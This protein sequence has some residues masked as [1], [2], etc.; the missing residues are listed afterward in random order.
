MNDGRVHDVYNKDFKLRYSK[1][2][3]SLKSHNDCKEMY[4]V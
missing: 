3:I 4:N 2:I 1:T